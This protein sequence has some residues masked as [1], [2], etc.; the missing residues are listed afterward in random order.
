MQTNSLGLRP[1]FAIRDQSSRSRLDA[2]STVHVEKSI[3]AERQR[4]FFALTVP[5]YMEAWLVIPGAAQGRAI[6]RP[7]EQSFSI[8]YL[9]GAA[10]FSIQCFYQ[11]CN[12]EKLLFDWKHDGAG[13]AHASFVTMRLMGEFERTNLELIHIG[14]DQS[15]LDWHRK[16]WEGSL[17]RLFTLF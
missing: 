6:V 9:D 15:M 10:R 11:A 13:S 1:R 5:E 14:L 7:D 2:R 16:L 8:S 4:V 17:A 3:P 12:K